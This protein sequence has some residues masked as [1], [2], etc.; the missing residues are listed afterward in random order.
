MNS[1]WMA[2]RY[3]N[4]SQKERCMERPRKIG[5][6]YTNSGIAPDE[7][8]QPKLSLDYDDKKNWWTDYNLAKH[9]MI[10]EEYEKIEEAK[11]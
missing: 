4:D 5:A 7:F 2:A 8:A 11:R 9:R 3:R 1:I 6:K 10:I